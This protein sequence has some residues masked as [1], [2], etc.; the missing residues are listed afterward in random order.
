MDTAEFERAL[1]ID[2]FVAVTKS[3]E[4]GEVLGDHHHD[5]EVRALVTS[6]ELTLTIGEVAT[7]YGVGQVFTMAAG[8]VHHE[9]VGASGVTYLAGRR[10]QN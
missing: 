1:T 4:P 10:Q 8:C 7:T 2:G 5:W 3:M 9:I 6:G